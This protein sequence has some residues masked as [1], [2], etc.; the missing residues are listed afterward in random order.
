MLF[1][2]FVSHV[3]DVV[4]LMA[5]HGARYGEFTVFGRTAGFFAVNFS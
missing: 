4:I 3:D 1:G 2:E 5:M